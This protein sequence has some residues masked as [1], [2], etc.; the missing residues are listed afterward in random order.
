MKYNT[1]K[2]FTCHTKQLFGESDHSDLYIYILQKYSILIR[3]KI[4]TINLI[5]KL[6]T[7]HSPLQ[8]ILEFQQKYKNSKHD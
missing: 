6:I 3:S 5:N 7:I 1:Y 8:K 4:K 2:V